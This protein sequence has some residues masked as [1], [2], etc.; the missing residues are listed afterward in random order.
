M[1]QY[2][3]QL[4]QPIIGDLFLLPEYQ[5]W[6]GSFFGQGKVTVCMDLCGQGKVTACTDFLWTGKAIVYLA[7]VYLWGML[8]SV[9]TGSFIERR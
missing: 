6:M 8:G 7:G 2:W 9:D 4:R 1:A 5:D 3:F